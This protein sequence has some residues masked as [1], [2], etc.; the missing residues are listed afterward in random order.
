MCIAIKS[1]TNLPEGQFDGIEQPKVSLAIFQ[2]KIDKSEH[3]N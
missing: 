2:P 3:D 1:L